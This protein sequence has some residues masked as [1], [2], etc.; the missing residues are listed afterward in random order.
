MAGNGAK[1]ADAKGALAAIPAVL[2]SPLVR[3]RLVPIAWR[4]ARRHP[5]VAALGALGAGAMWLRNQQGSS[6]I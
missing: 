5:V 6:S 4:F 2:A 1:G 3:K